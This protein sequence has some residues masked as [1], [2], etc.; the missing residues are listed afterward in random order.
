MALPAYVTPLLKP[1]H[2]TRKK[3]RFQ[4]LAQK[5]AQ[6]FP[7]QVCCFHFLDLLP[8]P[9]Q[10]SWAFRA[11]L[12]HSTPYLNLALA[13]PYEVILFS[14]QLSWSAIPRLLI[15]WP[16]GLFSGMPILNYLPK[17]E[18]HPHFSYPQTSY[19]ALS[20][21][22]CLKSASINICTQAGTSHSLQFQYQV[23]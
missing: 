15:L 7:L 5:P 16:S 13:S 3:T 8:F 12:V 2:P 20:P 22:S 9:F 11:H 10:F 14:N 21:H 4:M 18:A 23:L 19:P 6:S 1:S 17:R